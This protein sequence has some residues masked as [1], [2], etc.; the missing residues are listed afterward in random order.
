MNGVLDA[1][2]R[3]T[4]GKRDKESVQLRPLTSPFTRLARPGRRSWNQGMGWRAG[5]LGAE[6]GVFM[7][8]ARYPN[9]VLAMRVSNKT[10]AARHQ[11]PCPSAVVSHAANLPEIRSQNRWAI[12]MR[13]FA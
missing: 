10:S 2:W 8:M 4:S 7:M 11:G 12:E 1:S 6:S 3:L 5:W 9:G 13:G